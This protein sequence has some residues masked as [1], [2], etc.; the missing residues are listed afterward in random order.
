MWAVVAVSQ[1][2]EEIF[3]VGGDELLTPHPLCRSP[4]A[5]GLLL[6]NAHSGMFDRSVTLL[7]VCGSWPESFG[8]RHMSSVEATEEG[9]KERLADAMSESPSRDIV[10]S[11]TANSVLGS[12]N[13]CATLDWCLLPKSSLF[14]NVLLEPAT[15]AP[16]QS[17]MPAVMQKRE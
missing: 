3:P 11:G 15:G 8:L 14:D 16:Q 7:E 1:S 6:N 12:R 9:L 5:V 4:S 2:D 17:D 10:G 13:V